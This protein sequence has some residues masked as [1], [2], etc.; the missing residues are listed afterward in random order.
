MRVKFNLADRE[1]YL[2]AL[3]NLFKVNKSDVK[4][5]DVTHKKDEIVPCRTLGE[6]DE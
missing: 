4:R 5:N 2:D 1:K 3:V 6:K